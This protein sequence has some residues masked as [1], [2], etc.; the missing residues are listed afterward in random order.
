VEIQEGTL[1][2]LELQRVNTLEGRGFL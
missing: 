1:V 2:P